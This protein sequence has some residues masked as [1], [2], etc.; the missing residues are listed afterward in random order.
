MK[1][2]LLLPFCLLLFAHCEKTNSEA[3]TS[4]AT[5]YSQMQM[6]QYTE[7]QADILNP[8]RGFYT[9]RGFSANKNETLSVGDI[10]KYRQEGISLVFTI[11]YLREF[12]NKPISEAFLD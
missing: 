12:R 3:T 6:K 9:H 11:Y 10:Q 1:P 4:A 5:D 8:E 2:I 7:S